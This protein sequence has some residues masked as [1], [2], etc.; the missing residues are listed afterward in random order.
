MKWFRNLKI[1]NKLIVSFLLLSAIALAIGCLGIRNMSIINGNLHDIYN[2]ETIGISHIKEAEINLVSFSRAELSYLAATSA[3]ERDKYLKRMDKYG[4]QLKDN[5][6]RAKELLHTEKGREAFAKFEKAWEEYRE[7]NRK[8]LDMA[9]KEEFTAQRESVALAQGAGREKIDIVEELLSTL[10]RLKEE[11]GLRSYE[12]SDAI[13]SSSRLLMIVMMALGLFLGLGLG[14]L[15]S[16]IISRPIGECVAISNQLAEG[17][18][19]IQIE[20]TTRDETGQLLGAMKKMLEKLRVIVGEVRSAADNVASGSE[21][22]SA[23]AEQVSQGSTEQAA[24]AEEV[25]ASME[26]MGAN[27]RQ[28]ADNALQTERT[29][30]KSAEDASEGGRSVAETVTAMKEIAGKISIIEEIARQTNLLALNAAIEAARAGEHGKGFAVV[31]SE[32]RKLAERSQTAAAEISKLSISSVGIAENAGAMLQRIV[33]DIQKTAELVQEISSAC[34]EQNVGADQINKALQQLDLVIQQNA[35]AS[36]EMA[37]T[38]EELQSQAMQLRGSISFFKLGNADDTAAKAGPAR[39]KARAGKVR[40]RGV[41]FTHSTAT[42]S[43]P[44]RQSEGQRT[45]FT[46]SSDAGRRGV[47]I[48]LGDVKGN[49]ADEPSDEFDRY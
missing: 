32:V 33:P 8:V 23:T 24:S 26:Q 28:N 31:A 3:T 13:Y 6:A 38:S 42:A 9:A 10:S 15:V 21:E 14:V 40:G 18:L 2:K 41:S 20:V 17:R 48:N 39:E 47:S 16:R 36:E 30:V 25:S 11:A 1:A 43:V 12:E 19:E 27:I 34:N 29:A 7:I 46:D 45:L 35:A 22:L 44:A 5:A 49:G 4:Q 37:S